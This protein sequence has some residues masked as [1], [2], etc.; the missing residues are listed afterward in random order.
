[1]PKL[2]EC[3]KKEALL[4]AQENKC[5]YCDLVFEIEQLTRD[6]LTP[7]S[8]GGLNIGNI[9]LACRKCNGDKSNRMPTIV[10]LEKKDL[11]Y[12]RLA[13]F[14]IQHQLS[15][16]HEFLDGSG[17]SK[18]AS[19][20]VRIWEGQERKCFFCTALLADIR[21]ACFNSVGFEKKCFLTCETC[22][23]LYRKNLRILSPEDEKR[24]LEIKYKW[25][26]G[27]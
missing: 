17:K 3:T 14:V 27:K 2:Q 20:K 15:F 1:M 9:V 7:K 21:L 4:I 16:R 24:Y 19:K 26:L 5:F 6:H 8:C 25:I 11:I 13:C 22:G 12:K 10:E 23:I 18:T